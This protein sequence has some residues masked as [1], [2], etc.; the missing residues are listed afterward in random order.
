VTEKNYCE[1][2]LLTGDDTCGLAFS[3]VVIAILSNC[4]H[5]VWHF[6]LKLCIRCLHEYIVV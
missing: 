4:M 1:Y 2:F 6:W 5:D 3:N